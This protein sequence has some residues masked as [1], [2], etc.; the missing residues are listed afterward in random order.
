MR[1]IMFLAFLLSMLFLAPLGQAESSFDALFQKGNQHFQA[2][3]FEQARDAYH[4]IIQQGIRISKVFY[5][6]GNCYINTGDIGRAILFYR[7]ALKIDYRDKDI[8]TNLD[9]VRKLVSS[10]SNVVETKGF[11][12]ALINFSRQIGARNL[13]VITVVLWFLSSILFIVG[14]AA[15]VRRNKRHAYRLTL[16]TMILTLLSASLLGSLAYDNE[17]VVYAVAVDDPITARSGPGEH[18]SAIFDQISGFEMTVKQQQEGWAEVML[19]NGYTAWV[20]IASI[21]II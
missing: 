9:L 5:N 16:I 10:E 11:Y 12:S 8:L 7:R 14:F 13:V 15:R 3:D 19:S 20:P 4:S 18:F 21:E 2:G 1:R 17:C 6:L